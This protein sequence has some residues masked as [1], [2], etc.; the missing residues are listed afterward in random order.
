MIIL[1]F[2]ISF[3]AEKQKQEWYK[4][5][6]TQ[7]LKKTTR[8]HCWSLK[9][10]QILPKHCLETAILTQKC[11]TEPLHILF[12]TILFLEKQENGSFEALK[13]VL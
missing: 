13:Q 10:N 9:T 12:E 2:K 5:I 11:L 7:N 3:D 4:I 6:L 8:L 1:K